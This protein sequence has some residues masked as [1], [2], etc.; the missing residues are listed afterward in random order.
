[1]QSPPSSYMYIIKQIFFFFKNS[2]TVLQVYKYMYIY[3][4][5][6]DTV[7]EILSSKTYKLIH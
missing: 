3:I 6:I 7:L 5:Y 2:E 1:M 4:P